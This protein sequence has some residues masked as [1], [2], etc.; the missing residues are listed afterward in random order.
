MIDPIRHY[1]LTAMATVHDEEALTAL[2]LMGRNAAK[3]NEVIKQVNAN[4]Q[5]IEE[6]YDAIP[7]MVKAEVTEQTKVQFDKVYET[8]D[9]LHAEIPETNIRPGTV[10]N[11]SLYSGMFGNDLLELRQ[12]HYISMANR[13]SGGAGYI[14]QDTGEVIPHTAYTVSAQIPVEYGMYCKIDTGIYGN[15]VYPVAC[16]TAAGRFVGVKGAKGNATWDIVT[17]EVVIDRG[18][19]AYIRIIAGTQ[20]ISNTRVE[21]YTLKDFSVNE[22]NLATREHWHMHAKNRTNTITDRAQIKCWY[23]LPSDWVGTDKFS[24]GI[25]LAKYSN[26]APDGLT[27]RVFAAI[28]DTSYDSQQPESAAGYRYLRSRTIDVNNFM[29]IANAAGEKTTHVCLLIDIMA[30]DPSKYID[31]WLLP[32]VLV[33]D[34]DGLKIYPTTPECHGGVTGDYVNVVRAGA[35]LSSAYRKK[36]LGIGDSLMSGNSLNRIY[37]WFNIAA[38]ALDMQINNAAVNGMPVSYPDATQAS[39]DS[40]INDYLEAEKYD[41]VVVQG[42][43]NDKRLNVPLDTFR[44]GVRNIIMKIMDKQPGAKILFAT[45]WHRTDNA[46][47]LG[48]YD[49]EYVAAM[50]EECEEYGVPCVN[51]YAES[52]NLTLPG[53]SWA[54]QGW[55]VAQQPDIHFSKAGNKFVADRYVAELMKL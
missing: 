28:S 5:K 23:K 55:V 30:D 39:M 31:A 8:I 35:A 4:T 9:E 52:I 14:S 17:H 41:Y 7:D 42:G 12:N 51:N 53:T 49:Y 46:N 11:G 6:S 2:E 36:I 47:S 38:G 48:L 3:T 29:V 20:T 27:Y 33:R 50:I 18:D 32:P 37:S 26:V 22:I 40:T 43:A 10:Q 13:W 45:N 44:S 21:L 24:I 15:Q 1:S 54:D 19:I 25:T 16:Y 34:K